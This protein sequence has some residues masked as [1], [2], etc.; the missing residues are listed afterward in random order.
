MPGIES[1]RKNK[2]LVS[3]ACEM[4]IWRVCERCA[5]SEYESD[6]SP[7]Q[8]LTV[9]CVRACC[10]L[11]P[12][13][14]RCECGRRAH[15][16]RVCVCVCAIVSHSNTARRIESSSASASMCAH[17]IRYLIR[18]IHTSANQPAIQH[19]HHTR[20]CARSAY[21]RTCQHIKRTYHAHYYM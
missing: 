3:S 9:S 19:T 2:C 4:A 10:S 6:W 7:H 12:L 18:Y 17:A 16:L 21:R 1:E 11:L 20:C 8:R 15:C 5:P 13:H 14:V